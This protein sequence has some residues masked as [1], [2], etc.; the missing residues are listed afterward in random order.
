MMYGLA[1]KLAA[2]G[3]REYGVHHRQNVSKIRVEL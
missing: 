2:D 1:M 3:K